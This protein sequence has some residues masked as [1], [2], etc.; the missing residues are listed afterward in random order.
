VQLKSNGAILRDSIVDRSLY[1][2]FPARIS[3]SQSTKIRN[4]FKG[5]K[6]WEKTSPS[7][8]FFKT[9]LFSAEKE[10]QTQQNGDARSVW[11]RHGS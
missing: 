5:R 1:K 4:V 11:T 3:K 2:E 10:A 9:H 6:Y 8:R 7:R